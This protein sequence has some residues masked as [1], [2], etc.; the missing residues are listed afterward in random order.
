MEN[1][2]VAH[3]VVAE[4][5]SRF[6][7]NRIHDD[8]TAR[9]F[10]FTRGLVPGVEVHAYAC[11][12]TVRRW[13]RAWL[14]RGW[15]ETRFLRPVYDG[16]VAQVEAVEAGDDLSLAVRSEGVLCATGEAGLPLPEPPPGL[17][18]WAEP[19]APPATHPPASEATLAPG[20]R[21]GIAPWRLTASDAA[22][23]LRGVG[24]TDP[25]YAR[26]ALAHPGQILRLCNRALFE[27]VVLGPWVHVGSRVRNLAAGRVGQ[28]FTLRG[29]ILSN[30]E[31]KGHRFVEF[32][33][34]VLADGDVPVARVRHN[35]IWRLRGAA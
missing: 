18:D 24:E 13:G 20:I 32:D 2:P 17:D 5:L 30:T 14:E 23:Y 11:H 4:N 8:E 19:P 22:E 27:N 6:S 9:R 34:L 21:L 12:A 28:E 16:R 31:R 15:A 1:R 29:R 25:I 33:A 7:E 35:A 10:G 26:E 3:E